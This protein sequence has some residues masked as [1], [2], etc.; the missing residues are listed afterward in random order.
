M[1]I[2]NEN[3]RSCTIRDALRLH[4]RDVHQQ[5]HEHS[6]F[7]DL[8]AGTIDHARYCALMGLFYGFYAPLE[9]AIDRAQSG[10]SDPRHRFRYPKRSQLL[11]QDLESMGHSV[12]DVDRTPMCPHLHDIVTPASLAGVLYVIEGSTLGAAQIDRAAQ[13]ILSTDTPKGRSFW[14]WSRAN[15]KDRWAAINAYLEHLDRADQSQSAIIQGANDTF[16]ALST[17]LAPLD[18]PVLATESIAS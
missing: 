4:T 6:H 5:L 14:A 10:I 1:Q 7:V 13:K 16:Q 11:V 15:N 9:Q 17:W 3:S 8:F 2:A 12:E 18:Q